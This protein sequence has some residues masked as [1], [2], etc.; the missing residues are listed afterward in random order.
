LPFIN[1]E[2]PQFSFFD[3][4]DEYGLEKPKPFQ[5]VLSLLRELDVKVMLRFASEGA[6]T[7]RYFF[8][9]KRYSAIDQLRE[10]DKSLVGYIELRKIQV[11]E[12]TRWIAHKTLIAV[13]RT[14]DRYV[15]CFQ[16]H[17]VEAP[18]VGRKWSI[19]TAAHTQ[20]DTVEGCCAHA[21][22]SMA[23]DA[24]PGEPIR[25]AKD[26]KA[27]NSL[28][29]L[30]IVK[31][32]VTGGLDVYQI[33]EVIRKLGY[34]P[35]RYT[36][37]EAKERSLFLRMIY[38]GI[39]SGFP[40]IMGFSPNTPT[41]DSASPPAPESQPDL[42]GHVLTVVGHNFDPNHWFAE[43]AKEHSWNAG[44]RGNET[45]YIQSLSWTSS[46]LVHDDN[47]GPF[48]SI[49]VHY[50]EQNINGQF[51]FSAIVVTDL[52]PDFMHWYK[53]EKLGVN[54]FEQILSQLPASEF[55]SKWTQRL[56]DAVRS[57]KFI[58]RTT[59]SSNT[60]YA[61]HLKDIG[62]RFLNAEGVDILGA[63]RDYLPDRFWLTELSIPEIYTFNRSKIAEAI[64]D[65]KTALPVLIRMPEALIFLNENGDASIVWIDEPRYVPLKQVPRCADVG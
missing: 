59:V 7:H 33:E 43:A 49:P 31:Q 15:C 39:E 42:T 41:A 2:K 63:V 4:A 21:A 25:A 37:N 34:Q 18:E 64:I 56:R 17:V 53:A 13:K 51:E 19:F 54:Q 3:L 47:S 12:R 11:G 26:A 52:E 1:V 61:E 48:F 23:V 36:A 10:D 29:D 9:N 24:M 20:Q 5:R 35:M 45:G 8:F 28:L 55:P 32:P 38:N 22:I 58:V 62:I 65:Q 16:E 50:L 44:Y 6:A 40:V 30:D 27:I 46:L 60:E 57:R 14:P